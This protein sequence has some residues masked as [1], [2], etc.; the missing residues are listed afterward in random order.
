MGDM[1]LRLVTDHFQR[2]ICL[3]FWTGLTVFA[4]DWIRVFLIRCSWNKST[5]RQM[6][7]FMNV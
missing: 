7:T 2:L 5:A 6:R 1:F 4:R 3:V